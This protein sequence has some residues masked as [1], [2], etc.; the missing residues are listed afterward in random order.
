M[1]HAWDGGGTE[2]VAEVINHSGRQA[3]DQHLW[4]VVGDLANH[5]PAS[6]TTAMALAGMKRTSSTISTLVGHVR[7]GHAQRGLFDE[8]EV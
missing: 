7:E 3:N 8:M 6:D 4:A 5:L 2:A 1:A